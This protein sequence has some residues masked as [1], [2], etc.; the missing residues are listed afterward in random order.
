MPL[1]I[2][3]PKEIYP[4]ERR[5]AA[6]PATVGRFRKLGLEVQVEAGAGQAAGYTDADYQESGDRKS[7][8]LNSSHSS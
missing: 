4:G 5:V 3:I 8:R 2:G 1:T 6:T 7:T